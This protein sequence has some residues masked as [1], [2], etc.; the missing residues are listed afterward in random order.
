MIPDKGKKLFVFTLLCGALKGFMKAF[1]GLYKTSRGTTKK[2]ENENLSEF[3]F[4]YNFL[5]CTGRRG[6]K[7]T[8]Q[9]RYF[10]V[11]LQ[12]F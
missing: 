9:H 1:K 6:I 8:P 11:K 12:N 4:Y 3:L 2:C 5:K 7:Q 10:P